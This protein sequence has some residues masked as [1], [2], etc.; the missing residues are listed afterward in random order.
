MLHRHE[1]EI[2]RVAGRLFIVFWMYIDEI[3]IISTTTVCPCEM[4]QNYNV[5]AC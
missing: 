1:Q 5:S 4:T 2:I 3:V